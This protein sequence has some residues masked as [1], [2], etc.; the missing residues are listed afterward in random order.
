[1]FKTNI[2]NLTAFLASDHTILKEVVHPTNDAIDIGYSLAQAILKVGTSS[3]PHQLKSS[4]LYYILKGEGILFINDE[5]T[6]L[7]A[8][9]VVLVPPNATQYVQNTGNTDLEFLCI[10]EPYWKKDDEE[11]L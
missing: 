1:M 6:P 11:I 5:S 7:S 9:S 8:G 10:V 3:L 2:K 4:E